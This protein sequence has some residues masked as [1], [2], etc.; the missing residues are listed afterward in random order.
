MMEPKPERRP[1][2]TVPITVRR[3]TMADTPDVSDMEDGNGTYDRMKR[4][5]ETGRTVRRHLTT[6][7]RRWGRVSGNVVRL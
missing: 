4:K 1:R 6:N 7:D 2:M 5:K 3:E